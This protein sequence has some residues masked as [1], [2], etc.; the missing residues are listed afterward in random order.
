[1]SQEQEFL[2]LGIGDTVTSINAQEVLSWMQKGVI[3]QLHIS[4][5][6]PYTSLNEEDLG[7]EKDVSVD[8]FIQLGRKK[9][10]PPPIIAKLESLALRA[11][12]NL[13]EFSFACPW[14]RFVP[15][16]T[17]NAWRESNEVYKTSFYA[18]R[19]ELVASLPNSIET[20]REIYTK[21][22]E[23]AYKRLQYDKEATPPE[24]LTEN[25][26]QQC[27]RKVPDPQV[28]AGTFRYSELFS[29]MP[30]WDR[31]VEFVQN[32]AAE[33][34]E[35]RAEIAQ[36][37]VSQR[38]EMIASFLSEVSSSLRNMLVSACTKVKESIDKNENVLHGSTKKMLTNLLERVDA[39]NFCN[40]QQVI[41]MITD[42]R[43]S[44]V[45]QEGGDKNAEDVARAVEAVGEACKQQLEQIQNWSG[46]R[47]AALEV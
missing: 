38:R 45:S 24:E 19:D 4:H 7:I 21:M 13:R 33:E 28:V 36:Q 27:L 40:D 1:M 35:T 17:W 14:G 46:S 15:V 2:E 16:S 43:A 31:A 6:R 23:D 42:I 44:L 32:G 11:R 41:R 3:V 25:F 20:L 37:M 47:F 18:L 12:T 29:Y 10:L 22:A 30:L 34:D 9:L 26:V 39:L 8:R 5:W